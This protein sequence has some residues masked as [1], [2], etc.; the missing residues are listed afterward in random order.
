MS[1]YIKE[2]K[3]EKNMVSNNY[4]EHP[5]SKPLTEEADYDKHD[6]FTIGGQV[7]KFHPSATA[8]QKKDFIHAQLLAQMHANK[9]TNKEDTEAWYKAYTSVLENIGFAIN[10]FQFEK[11][12]SNDDSARVD[13]VLLELLVGLAAD[14]EIMALKTVLDGIKSIEQDGGKTT[15]FSEV[16]NSNAGGKFQISIGKENEN[17]NWTTTLGSYY[18]SRHDTRGNF[19]F[20][21]WGS[22]TFDVWFSGQKIELDEE[23]F[24]KVR[25]FINEK[26]GIHVKD[27]VRKMEI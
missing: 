15:L 5:N 7:T 21:S 14:N 13:T 3:L 9:V 8:Q 17:G 10:S 23:T 11:V 25:P 19:L 4:K 1:K 16:V 27:F 20:Y 26:I 24:S 6:S 22:L 12:K 18:T 2:L